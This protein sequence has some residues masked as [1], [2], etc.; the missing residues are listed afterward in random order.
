MSEIQR[1]HWTSNGMKD[2][3]A[4]TLDVEKWVLAAAL[5]AQAEEHKA[6]L[7]SEKSRIAL[8]QEKY[9]S[10]VCMRSDAKHTAELAAKDEGHAYALKDIHQLE[11]LLAA[12][13]KQREEV[14]IQHVA[15][16]AVLREPALAH[17]THPSLFGEPCMIHRDYA[18]TMIQ[19]CTIAHDCEV[20]LWVTHS[21]RRLSQKLFDKVVEEAERSNHHAGS[22]V[23]LNP[24]YQGVWY[25]SEMMEDLTDPPEPV[26][27]FLNDVRMDPILR[28]GGAFNVDKDRV[29]FDDSLVLRNSEEWA[30]RVTDLQG[31]PND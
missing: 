15:E 13:C 3:C 26:V 9:W 27:Q 11:T 16:L 21:M 12:A 6:E 4:P 7:Q 1:Y 8:M 17:F 2:G 25:T 14:L 19:L 30:R 23:D 31:A 18:P 22:A 5:E 20:K 10:A 28:W 24:V 29:H